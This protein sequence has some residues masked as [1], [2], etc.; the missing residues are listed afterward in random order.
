MNPFADPQPPQQ[1]ECMLNSVRFLFR[2]LNRFWMVP[3]FRLG[4]GSLQVNPFSGYM[5]VLK[6]IGHKTGKTRYVPVN[7]VVDGGQVYFLSGMGNKAHWYKNLKAA[8]MT[9]AILP[10]RAIHG[11]V[12]EIRAGAERLRLIRRILKAGGFAGFFEGINSFTIPD[13]Q[14]AAKTREMVLFRLTPDGIGTGASDPGGWG[15]ILAF[16]FFILLTIG[17]VALLVAAL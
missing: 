10:G 5:M 6:T 11:K 13:K 12:S 4:I 8:P 2:I 17:V 7:Y 9:E 16:V 1:E 14:L 3:V 15:W